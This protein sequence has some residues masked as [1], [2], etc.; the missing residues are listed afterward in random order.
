MATDYAKLTENLFRFYDFTGKVVLF[1]G[2]ADGQL[3]DPATRTRKLIAI[4]KDVEALRELK[5]NIVA[6]GLQDSLEVIGASFQEVKLHGD[7]VYFEFC[8]H[9]MED[10]ENALIHAKSLAPD[11]VVY[12]HSPGS[13]WIYYGAEDNE[14]ARSSAAME[15]F[16][17]R[18]CERFQTEQ[19]FGNYTELL[20]KVGR[21]GP[22]AIERTQEFAGV[23]DIV[24]PMSY[25]LNLL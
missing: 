8:L 18:R 16:G 12:D 10:P 15:R 23:T 14:V 21:Q 5:A 25:E 6:K 7:A 3:L 17:I 11:I 9:E 24:I 2:A 13:E 20:A 19:R 4:D 1:I 22:L